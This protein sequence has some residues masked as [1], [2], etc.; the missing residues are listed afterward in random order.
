MSG[1]TVCL[2]RPSNFTE[3]VVALTFDDGPSPFTTP[4]ILRTLAKYDARAT[5]FMV[6][7]MVPH[8]EWLVRHIASLGHE[9]GNHSHSHRP[10]PPQAVAKFEV[11]GTEDKLAAILGYG[12]R[13]YRPP[14][15]IEDS[16][17]TVRARQKGMPIVLWTGDT[18][19]WKFK[20][21]QPVITR[22][23]SALK[24][25][26]VLLM[27][28]IHEHTAN[29]V[30]AIM[31]VIHQRGYKCITISEM[32]TKW[33]DLALREIAEKKAKAAAAAAAA[34]ATQSGAGK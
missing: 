23:I 25:G 9:I 27:H 26:A 29:A 17:T 8:R 11:D 18:L 34:K 15:G 31:A 19:D 1:K 2:N 5:F 32:M 12:P 24:P 4:R 16:S 30:P 3:K 20:S 7:Q 6:G 13:T 22:A 14:Y 28:D 21:A 33:N 10:R